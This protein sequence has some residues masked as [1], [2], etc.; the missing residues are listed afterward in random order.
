ME[1]KQLASP[2]INAARKKIAQAGKPTKV[3][4]AVRVS[5]KLVLRMRDASVVGLEA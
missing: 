1:K 3:L 5:L 4:Q 2:D